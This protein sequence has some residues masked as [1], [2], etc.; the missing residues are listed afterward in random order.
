MR[1][2]ISRIIMLKLNHFIICHPTTFDVP[3]SIF[4]DSYLA[5]SLLTTY[6]CRRYSIGSPSTPKSSCDMDIFEA[7][8]STTTG[9]T[10]LRHTY[11]Q[12]VAICEGCQTH[13]HFCARP[14]CPVVVVKKDKI[15]RTCPHQQSIRTSTRAE[16][17][18]PKNELDSFGDVKHPTEVCGHCSHCYWRSLKSPN[19]TH[20]YIYIYTWNSKQPVLYACFNWMIQN[21]YMGNGCLTKHPLKTGR[22]EFQVY[23]QMLPLDTL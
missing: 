16:L 2:Y 11:R 18:N 6:S 15:V 9:A 22:L 7:D 14:S 4:N 23:I 10:Q 1:L 20:M 12:S 19:Y 21:L 13:T 5:A 8:E 17:E 3:I